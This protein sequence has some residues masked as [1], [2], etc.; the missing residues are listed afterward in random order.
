MLPLRCIVFQSP[1]A[2]LQ[3]NSRYHLIDDPSLL[4]AAIA[5]GVHFECCPTSS[6]ETGG[7]S[8]QASDAMNWS[9]HPMVSLLK[10]G[11][12]VGVNS[13]DPAVFATSLRD[14][15]VLCATT[16]IDSNENISN[17]NHKKPSKDTSTAANQ[18]SSSATGGAAVSD[19]PEGGMGLKL[20][21]LQ[22]MTLMAAEAAFL[23]PDEK[24]ALR[25]S[26]ERS[27]H[28]AGMA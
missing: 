11:A 25:K 4:A 14:E 26:L 19:F 3:L 13:D 5:R 17:K 20:S 21:D 22:K 8:G 6:F 7:W 28:R 10:S 1:H 24:A 9:Q 23:P 15:L 12:S 16:P 27:F 2:W 18:R